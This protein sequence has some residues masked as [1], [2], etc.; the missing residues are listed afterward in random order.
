MKMCHADASS[1][2]YDGQVL[3]TGGTSDGDN[4]L[5]TIE[6]FRK[7]PN[8]LVPAC[9]SNFPVNLPKPL[10]GHYTF[11]H[12]DRVIVIGY[13]DEDRSTMIYEIQLYFPFNTK[14]LAKC[15]LRRPITGSGVVLVNNKIFFFGGYEEN[16]YSA[17]ANVTMHDISKNEFKELAPLPYPV[18]QMAAVQFED[19]AVLFGGLDNHS[20]KDTVVSYNLETQESIM[21]KPMKE[22]LSQCSAVVDGNSMVVM[23]GRDKRGTHLKSVKAFDFKSSKWRT[24]KSMNESRS[25]FIAEIV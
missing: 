22:K 16:D 25:S 3:V 1:V 12:E 20:L 10:R 11:V 19:N 18:H 23:G 2:S 6:H 4:I 5:S 9:W 15:H 7:N 24:L 14:V 13:D 21:L 8:P 17:L